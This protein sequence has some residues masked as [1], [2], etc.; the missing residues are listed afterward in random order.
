VAGDIKKRSRRAPEIFNVMVPPR[1]R[2]GLDRGEVV[3]P[4]RP[5]RSIEALDRY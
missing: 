4:K 2:I 5:D 3:L 1:F